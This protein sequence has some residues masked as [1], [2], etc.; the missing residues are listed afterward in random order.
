MKLGRTEK[1]FGDPGRVNSVIGPGATFSGEC[2]VEGT[3]RID[4]EMVGTLRATGMAVIGK[5]GVVRGDI[6]VENAIIGGRVCG[7]VNA[8][9]RVELQSGAHVEGDIT[10]A[11][12]IVEEG[13]VFNGRC[14][15]TEG[16]SG[17]IKLFG[18][19]GGVEKIR[20]GL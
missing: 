18:S 13:T 19:G 7:N 15:M 14:S 5:T 2:T 12:L 17:T 9:G 8:T 10:T 20:E 6:F 4:G 3:V 11:K 16:H 1:D